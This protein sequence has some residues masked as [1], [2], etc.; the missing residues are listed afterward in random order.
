M[1]LPEPRI[2]QFF[3]MQEMASR[4]QKGGLPYLGVLHAVLWVLFARAGAV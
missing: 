1:R 2:W 3:L 4:L